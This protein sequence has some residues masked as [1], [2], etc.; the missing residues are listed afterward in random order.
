METFV[1]ALDLYTE[2]DS[3]VGKVLPALQE[4]VRALIG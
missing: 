3:L 4:R 2:M 1:V